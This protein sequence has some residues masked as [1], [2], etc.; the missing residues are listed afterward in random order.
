MA[1]RA[2]EIQDVQHKRIGASVRPF[3][4]SYRGIRNSL[5]CFAALI[6][7]SA[8]TMWSAVTG[9]ISGTITDPSG[10]VIP[11]ATVVIVNIAQGVKTYNQDGRQRRL[12]LSELVR[13]NL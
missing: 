13:W 8:A 1:H 5:F 6:V 4:G 12:H 10:S 2:V 11:N 7:F 9:S 3:T